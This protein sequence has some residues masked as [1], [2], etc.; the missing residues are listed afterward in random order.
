MKIMSNSIYISRSFVE[1]G[2]FLPAEILDFH[3]RGILG[4]LNHVR[5]H[6]QDEWLFIGEWAARTA[7]PAKT[8]GAKTTARA[9]APARATAPKTPAKKAGVSNAK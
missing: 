1:F 6:G 7:K 3:Q 9:K 8:T 4:P 5:A 2:P